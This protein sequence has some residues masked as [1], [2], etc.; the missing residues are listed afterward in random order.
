MAALAHGTYL[1]KHDLAT[2]RKHVPNTFVN[3]PT[4]RKPVPISVPILATL[5]KTRNLT[6]RFWQR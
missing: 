5:G 6:N 1:N 4:L 3:Q 2:L